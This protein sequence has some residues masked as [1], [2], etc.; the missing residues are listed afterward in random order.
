MKLKKSGLLTLLISLFILGSCENPKGIGLDVDPNVLLNSGVVDTSTVYTKLIKEDSIAANFTDRSVL[1]YLKDTEFG[2]TRTNIMLAPTLPSANFSFGTN[3]ILDSAVL[4]LNYHKSTP[5]YGDSSRFTVNVHQL[6][7]KLYD[8]ATV[9]Y[10]N[11]IW[12]YNNTLV[13]TTNFYPAYKDSVS[14]KVYGLSDSVIKVVPQLRIPLNNQFITDNIVNLDSAKLSTNQKFADFFKGL[15]LS[16]DAATAPSTGASISFDTYT[17]G[18]AR[19]ELYYRYTDLSNQQKAVN[20][21]LPVNGSSGAAVTEVT[22]NLSGSAAETALNNPTNNHDKLY[23]KG[24]GGTKIQLEF[25]HLDSLK[26]LGKNIAVN[27]AELIFFVEEPINTVLPPLNVFRPYRW[28]L[29]HQPKPLPEEDPADRNY[30]GEGYSA[31]YYDNSSKSYVINVTG[32]IQDLFRNKTINHGTFITTLDY[33]SA[34]NRGKLNAIGR[35]ILEGGGSS[36][37]K[38]VKLKIYYSDLK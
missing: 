7:E 33:L 35:S 22:W 14:I 34:S 11:K 28:D 4:V 1:S 32:Y 25:P 9:Y 3:P 21:A 15:R 30:M 18:A 17:E 31:G 5:L 29:A 8:G 2:E 26:N 27:R 10:N 12:S 23:V 38:K 16:I 20:V 36:S 19:L 37:S 13:G 24:L 6:T